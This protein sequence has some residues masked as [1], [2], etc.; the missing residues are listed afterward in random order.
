MNALCATEERSCATER[1]IRSFGA[2]L[3]CIGGYIPR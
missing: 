3:K 1:N 2:P